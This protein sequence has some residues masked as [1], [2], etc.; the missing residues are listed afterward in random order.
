M[1]GLGEQIN[2]R[3]RNNPGHRHSRLEQEEVK[4]GAQCRNPAIGGQQRRGQPQSQEVSAYPAA[5]A[6][7]KTKESGHQDQ[8]EGGLR[9]PQQRLFRAE[10]RKYRQRHPVRGVPVGFATNA[11][12]GFPQQ[13]QEQSQPDG[14]PIQ[15]IIDPE[16]LVRSPP[17][18]EGPQGAAAHRREKA[19]RDPRQESDPHADRFELT[20]TDQTAGEG[21]DRRAR[22]IGGG[23][24]T[25]DAPGETQPKRHKQ[26]TA[27]HWRRIIP[28]G[29]G[30]VREG[31]KFFDKT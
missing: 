31:T 22:E 5:R 26:E 29:G 30:D 24:S 3:R 20:K 11:D 10:R 18:E 25:L 27:Y 14:D 12:L 4:S 6:G 21:K 8:G 28:P 17:Q 16:Q 7:Q 2:D 15:A 9:F 23:P 1:R 19:P 13:G